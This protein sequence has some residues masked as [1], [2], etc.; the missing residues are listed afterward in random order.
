MPIVNFFEGADDLPE[1]VDQLKTYL[2][3]FGVAAV[4]VDPTDAR[5]A[6]FQPVLDA[7][8][9]PARLVDGVW[10]YKIPTDTLAGYAKI[11]PSAAEARAEALRMDAVLS[12]A[13]RYIADGHDAPSL[14]PLELQRYGLLPVDWHVDAARYTISDWSVGTL[15]D[16]RIAIALNGSYDGLKPLME[17]YANGAAEILYPAPA[18]WNPRSSPPKDELRSM[19]LIL[20]RAQVEAAAQ[21]LKT[22]PPPEMTTPFLAL[23]ER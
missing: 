19:V 9:V 1:P 6:K 15:P 13:A 20:S 22:S 14:S 8:K 10:I 11:R 3:Q 16:G 4:L 18:R 5:F 7:L 23:E 21:S 12:A 17:R 2:A